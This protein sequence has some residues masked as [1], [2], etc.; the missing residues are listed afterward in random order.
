MKS[1]KKLS[2]KSAKPAKSTKSVK[3]KKRSG[4]SKKSFK[5]LKILA[6]AL[7]F[8]IIWII[9]VNFYVVLSTRSQIIPYEDANCLKEPG[10]FDCILVLGAG[11]N[12]D[13][14]SAILEDRLKVAIEL[15]KK[16]VSSKIIMSGDHGTDEHDEVNIMKS[17]AVE[18]GVRSEDVFMD[19]AGF[20]TYDSIYRAKAIFQA[21]KVIIVT[22]GYHLYRAL[23]IANELGVN[24]YGVPADMHPYQ[25]ILYY[26]AREVIA[27]NKDFL[28]C[29]FKPNPTY[30]GEAIPV[31]GN[32]DVTNDK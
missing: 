12:G 31:S 29:L 11:I 8:V 14:P 3:N 22:Q 2:T 13:K 26:K 7:T 16:N 25:R 4:K 5:L 20:S 21:K 19:H 10:G 27:R 32:G 17:Y 6:W 30:L 24:A 15:Y 28:M 1:K 23:H 18:N 9:G